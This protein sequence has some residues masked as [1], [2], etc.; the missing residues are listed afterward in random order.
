[1]LKSTDSLKKVIDQGQA[2]LRT[3]L[4]DVPFVE[5]RQV[6][7]DEQPG[8]V[9]LLVEI[10]AAGKPYNL[11]CEIISNGQPRYV[12]G[13]LLRLRNVSAPARN[14]YIPLLIAPYLSPATRLLCRQN[15]VNCLDLMGNAFITFDKVYINREVPDQPKGERREMKSLFRPRSALVLKA[16]LR[17]PGKPWRVADLAQVTGV[18]LG[19][20]SNVRAGLLDREWA[21]KGDAGI[22]LT[23]PDELLDTWK[24]NY[25]PPSGKPMSF[26]TTLHGSAFETAARDALAQ[27]K[28]SKTSQ[29]IAAFA[30]FTAANWLAPY[31]RNSNRYFYANESGMAALVEALKLAPATKG[32]NVTITVPDDWGVFSDLEEPAP[33]AVCT[34]LIQTY[35]DLSIAGERGEES[36]EY[37][38]QEKMKWSE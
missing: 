36:A 7:H 8:R 23:K 17:D 37:L 16:M 12:S 28:T 22:Y 19:H 27:C 5:I 24:D 20:V 30:S 1:M 29:G 33:G 32:A 2:A 35:L 3:L 4:S 34:S 31:G 6:T 21:A 26:Y 38:R 18:S 10:T 9:D 25:E 13:A 15:Q 11:I 14:E